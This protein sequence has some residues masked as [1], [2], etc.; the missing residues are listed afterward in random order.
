M[1]SRPGWHTCEQRAT[2]RPMR[3]FY[4]LELGAGSWFTQQLKWRCTCLIISYN[5]SVFAQY[6]LCCHIKLSQMADSA[7][8]CKHA[9][10]GCEFACARPQRARTERSLLLWSWQP[11]R[12]TC[13]D[14][15]CLLCPPPLDISECSC[16]AGCLQGAA[17]V[18]MAALCRPAVS[19]PLP[20]YSA[21]RLS[22]QPSLFSAARLKYLP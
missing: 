22:W 11:N 18:V 16:S 1:E 20:N 15:R 3:Y 14:A 9:S 13:R 19:W 12:K 21:L 10:A 7:A 6:L 2:V 8:A 17:A 5:W 4:N